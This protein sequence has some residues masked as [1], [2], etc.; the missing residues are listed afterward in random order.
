MIAKPLSVPGQFLQTVER[1]NL[2]PGGSTVLVAVSGG[3]DSVALLHLIRAAARRKGWCVRAFHLNHRLRVAATEEEE[4]V[5]S[6]CLNWGVSLHVGYADVAG[7]AR[8]RHRSIEETAREVRYRLLEEARQQ[9]GCHCVALGHNADDNLETVIM[10]LVRGAGLRGLAGIPVCR[11]PFVRPLLDIERQRIRDYLRARC[12]DWKEDESNL[13]QR[14]TR[15]MIRA[16]IV[17][18]LRVLNPTVVQTVRRVGQ[19]LRAEDEFLD[20]R[21]TK[22]LRR[23]CQHTEE[24][25]VFDTDR[26]GSYNRVLIRRML[27]QLVPELDAGATE[28]VLELLTRHRGRLRLPAGIE[29]HKRGTSVEFLWGKRRK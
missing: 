17:P 6:L 3:A 1:H 22:V 4:F 16:Q 9:L 10:N 11:W 29:V 12:V 21:A 18:L 15:N 23:V 26:M 25:V 27:R 13:D 20:D 8:K 19:L 14:F 24:G 7:E 28:R 5:R 2:I